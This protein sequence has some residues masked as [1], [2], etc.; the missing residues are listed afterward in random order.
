MAA[1]CSR[2]AALWSRV[3]LGNLSRRTRILTYIHGPLAQVPLAT[4]WGVWDHEF[5]VTPRGDVWEG[6]EI[7]AQAAAKAS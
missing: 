2:R 6:N 7:L 1:R 5:V 3:G 4:N